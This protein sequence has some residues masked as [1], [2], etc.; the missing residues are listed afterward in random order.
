MNAII[1]I[2]VT[3]SFSTSEQPMYMR[4]IYDFMARNSRE[5]SIMKGDVVQ[6]RYKTEKMSQYLPTLIHNCDFLDA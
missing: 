6:V 2:A 5:L 1:C 3:V 4:V